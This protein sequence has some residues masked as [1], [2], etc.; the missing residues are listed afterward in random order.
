LVLVFNAIFAPIL[1]KGE[2]VQ[3]ID[4]VGVAIIVAGIVVVVVF[5]PRSE[6][7]FTTNQLLRLWINTPFIIYGLIILAVAVVLIIFNHFIEQKRTG[8]T[9]AESK[10]QKIKDKEEKKKARREKK[11]VQ[12]EIHLEDGK[13]E[14]AKKKK[15]NAAAQPNP[16]YSVETRMGKIVAVSYAVLPAILSSFNALFSKILGEIVLTTA[17]GHDQF[18]DW[19]TYL[20]VVLFAVI[21]GMQVVYLQRALRSYSAL[22]II[23]LYQ[24]SLTVF[25]V[26]TGGIFFEEFNTFSSK[27]SYYPAL[28]VIGLLVAIS[29]VILLSKR[30]PT[31][32]PIAEKDSDSMD[33]EDKN[34]EGD[35]DPED[36]PPVTT[37]TLFVFAALTGAKWYLK[38]G[39][40]KESESENENEPTANEASEAMTTTTST[41]PLTPYDTASSSLMTG[42]TSPLDTAK[43]DTT[44][45]SKE[46][47]ALPLD[48]VKIAD[49]MGSS[50]DS[51]SS[52]SGSDST[53]VPESVL[54][55]PSTSKIVNF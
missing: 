32:V 20:F 9:K 44:D 21:D 46:L 26:A 19:A 28:F 13:Y 22:Y 1:L 35:T 10:K 12:K 42:T 50:S 40:Y 54:L 47:D 52:G 5:G 38:Q 27:P 29:G 6:Q 24:V 16:A 49:S 3:K 18:T 31:A 43:T 14:L 7:T 11:I 30:K 25:G 17:R 51:L 33:D 8:L 4:V 55:R 48:D 37:G 36:A 2:K 23:P 34:L 15:K 39:I 41:D 45:S 53:S